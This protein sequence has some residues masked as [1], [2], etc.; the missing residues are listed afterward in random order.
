VAAEVSQVRQDGSISEAT[1]AQ[2]VFRKLGLESE[3]ELQL[4]LKGS[5]SCLS[6]NQMVVNGFDYFFSIWVIRP[7]AGEFPSYKDRAH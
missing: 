7:V 4:P 3:K 6:T 1:A 5:L 2:H